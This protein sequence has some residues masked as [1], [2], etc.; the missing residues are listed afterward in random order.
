[1]SGN[2]FID[3]SMEMG[4]FDDYVDKNGNRRIRKKRH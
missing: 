1:M 2:L 4:K 3:M